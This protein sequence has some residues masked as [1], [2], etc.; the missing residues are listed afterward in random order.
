MA[1]VPAY[2]KAFAMRGRIVGMEVWN[3]DVLDLLEPA[4]LTIEGPADREIAFLARSGF[5]SRS[6]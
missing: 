4:H 6:L 5:L 3:N 2:A 1:K